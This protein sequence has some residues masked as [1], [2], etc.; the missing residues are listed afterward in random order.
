MPAK[1]RGIYRRG[2]GTDRAEMRTYARLDRGVRIRN[3]AGDEEKALCAGAYAPWVP[4]RS[5]MSPDMSPRDTAQ[6]LSALAPSARKRKNSSEPPKNG[7]TSGAPL[8]R[9]EEVTEAPGTRNIKAAFGKVPEGCFPKA[10]AQ[11]AR[12]PH[13]KAEFRRTDQSKRAGIG[14]SGICCLRLAPTSG[15]SAATELW[16]SG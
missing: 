8:R 7:T 4:S 11:K 15:I 1:L 10:V 6:H 2:C 5:P 12:K 9:G 13:L 3:F 14:R 16:P